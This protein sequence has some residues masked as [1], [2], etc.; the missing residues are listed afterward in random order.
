MTQRKNR[1]LTGGA[2]LLAVGLLAGCGRTE[3]AAAPEG[4]DWSGRWVVI[5]Y[6]AEWC[7]PC[8]E[9][10]PELNRL[11]REH[12]AE[13]AVLGVNYDGLTGER[14]RRLAEEMGIEFRLLEED[15]RERWGEP[16]P[17]VL[18]STLIVNPDGELVDVLVGPQDFETFSRVLA[19]TTST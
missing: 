3:Q 19:L 2:V 4:D 18:P 15:P 17:S 8:R 11:D 10:I 7:A 1:L 9:E 6:W 5:N 13:V 14:L 12:R 16:Q